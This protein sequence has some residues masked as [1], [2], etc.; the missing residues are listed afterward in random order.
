MVASGSQVGASVHDVCIVGLKCWGFLSGTK[1]SAYIGGIERDLVTLARMLS[2]KGRNVAM[3]TYDE[4]QPA[5]TLV[6]G[7]SVYGCF[8]PD[9]GLPGIRFIHPRATCLISMVRRIRAKCFA[10][11]GADVTTGWTG[12]ACKARSQQKPFIFLTGS[13]GDCLKD[14][15]FLKQGRERALYRLGL[16]LADT[17]VT[18][19]DAQAA[20][21]LENFGWQSTVVRLPSQ[22]STIE[23][24]YIR[25]AEKGSPGLDRNRRKLRILWVGRID[26]MKRPDWV[27]ELAEKYPNYQFEIAGDANSPNSYSMEFKKSAS[28]VENIVLHG[29]VPSQ[30]MPDLYRSADV[31]LCTS[32]LEGF[33]ATFLE[34]WSFAL[35]IIST[36]DPGG[37]IAKYESGAVAAS[38]QALYDLLR[39]ENLKSKLSI[40]SDNAVRLYSSHFS[41]DDCL[42]RFE[43]V[44]CQVGI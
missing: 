14:L 21:M 40:W 5:R 38:K 37:L 31:L 18:Q 22:L 30:R 44:L 42:R 8:S 25:R 9:V 1:E 16:R 10:Q 43:N 19:T 29:R 36:V 12:L 23:S 24:G 11:M 39:Y 34:A 41:P 2:E 4:G 32:E 17:V 27:A 13:D 6:D 35:P 15:P 3:V 20:L 28:A 33:P 26:R 7:I